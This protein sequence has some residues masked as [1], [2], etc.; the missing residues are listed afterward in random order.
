MA[1]SVPCPLAGPSGL[2]TPSYAWGSAVTYASKPPA[3]VTPGAAVRFVHA[4]AVCPQAP[5]WGQPQARVLSR[6]TQ[7]Q[8]RVLSRE[9]RP[10]PRVLSRGATGA[11]VA[12]LNAPNG[13]VTPPRAVTPPH[14]WSQSPPR[15]R[16]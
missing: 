15:L 11:A 4:P 2:H 10:Q 8:A 9:S 6:E 3:L 7:P 5:Q 16:H 12:Q 1:C 14:A 13:V